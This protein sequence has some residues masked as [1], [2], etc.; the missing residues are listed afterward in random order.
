MKVYELAR[1]M[2]ISVNQIKLAAGD[3][4]KPFTHHM[5]DVSPPVEDEIREYFN[6]LEPAPEP[7]P[8]KKATKPWNSSDNPWRQD[9]LAVKGQHK[10]F[11]PR[12]VDSRENVQKWA[13]RGYQIADRKEYEEVLAKVPGEEAQVGSHLKRRELIL[14]ETTEENVRMHDEHIDR[15]SNDAMKAAV[16]TGDKES[17]KIE[18]G[19]KGNVKFETEFTSKHGS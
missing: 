4:G 3:M 2:G 15:M 10:G 18:K 12:W 9:L 5:L 13:D 7:E 6:A 14:M 19:L 11:K 8:K 16:E 17:K 1:D